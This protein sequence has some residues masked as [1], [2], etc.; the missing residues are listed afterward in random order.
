MNLDQLHEPVVVDP[1]GTVRV[2][3]RFGSVAVYINTGAGAWRRMYVS[4][5]SGESLAPPS[6]VGDSVAVSGRVVFVPNPFA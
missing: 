3:Q 5:T 4:T 6:V 1:I 2:S